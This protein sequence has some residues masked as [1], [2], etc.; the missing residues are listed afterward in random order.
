MLHLA[1][2]RL[3]SEKIRSPQKRRRGESS[4]FGLASAKISLSLL[5]SLSF[6]FSATQNGFRAWLI[7]QGDAPVAQFRSRHMKQRQIRCNGRRYAT[8]GPKGFSNCLREMSY[9]GE[10]H[11]KGIESYTIRKSDNKYINI[12]YKKLLK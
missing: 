5:F 10:F 8:P 11:K 6:Y 1:D 2:Q 7:K 12:I 9:V 4:P 3:N